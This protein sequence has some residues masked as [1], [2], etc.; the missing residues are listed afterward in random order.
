MVPRDMPFI[1]RR[2]ELDLLTSALADA[3]AGR[4]SAV[5]LSGEPGIGKTRLAQEY[6][7]YAAS[8]GALVLW[9]RCL[10]LEGT[11][12]FWP[13][14]EVIRAALRACDPDT[15][16]RALGADAATIARLAPEL[17]PA[18]EPARILP[19]EEEPDFDDPRSR[20]RLFDATATFLV[21]LAA[22]RT[23][24]LVLDDLHWA[25]RPSLVLLQYL[26]RL[27]RDAHLLVAGLYRD[28]V[29]AR[30]HPLAGTMAALTR[31]GIAQKV[32]LSGWSAEEVTR[33]AA[34]VA[35]GA[36]TTD[37][38]R[39]IH[40]QTDGNPF[41]VI[42]SLRLLAT[43]DPKTLRDHAPTGAIP[44]G[45]RAVVD[46]RL[47]QLSSPCQEALALA[48]VAGST[49]PLAV[50][51]RAGGGGRLPLLAALEEAE[52]ARLILQAPESP[53][54]FRFA[55][56]LFR[57]ALYES[58]PAIRRMLLHRAVGEA[59]ESLAVGAD[60]PLA[61]LA[62]HFGRAAPSGV[63]E[64][65]VRYAV[66][67]AEQAARALA[68][69]DAAAL[70]RAAL[71]I[72]ATRRPVDTLERC[73]LLLALGQA[74]WSLG[75]AHTARDTFLAAAALA[76]SAA[77]PDLLTRAALGYS[78]HYEPGEVEPVRIGL[79]RE[80][81]ALLD[82][83]AGSLRAQVMAELAQ[84]LYWANAREERE[85]LSREAVALARRLDD[86]PTLGRV[87]RLRTL[88][89]WNPDTTEERLA[90]GDEL[91]R[92]G[93]ATGNR[94]LARGGAEIRYAAL[95][96]LGDIA[97]IDAMLDVWPAEAPEQRHP[98]RRWEAAM[99][100][101][102]RVLLAGRLD[103]AERLAGEAVQAGA[104]LQDQG[105]VYLYY[106][107]QIFA[108][109]REQDRLAE[110]EPAIR[111][112]AERYPLIPAY[113][114]GLAWIA[115]E[116]D[117]PDEARSLLDTLAAD[118]FAAIPFDMG[119]PVA[120]MALAQACAALG[121]AHRAASLYRLLLP[122]ANRCIVA[123]QGAV[124]YGS[125]SLPL[126]LLAATICR[127]GAHG[128]STAPSR[129]TAARHF[130]DALAVN[131]RMGA[132][133]AL[134]WTQYQY[135][136]FLLDWNAHRGTMN[137]DEC[138]MMHRERHR[139]A[140]PLIDQARSTARELGMTRLLRQIEAFTARSTPA[141]HSS[142]IP[143]RSSFPD[144]LTAREVQ[145]LR[146]LAAGKSNRA[147][148]AEC[149]L[150]IRTVERHIANIYAKIG[151]HNKAEATAYAFRHGLITT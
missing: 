131:A 141:P 13:W 51:E 118:E 46:Q 82:P 96:E 146:L 104:R 114:A 87:L 106:G 121:D 63:E 134:A 111:A 67:A 80:A 76:R 11:P 9:G 117:R 126:A 70:Y 105:A 74:Q 144:A 14:R 39:A 79:L 97:A 53:G 128:D 15:L 81:L 136:A 68:Y 69:E 125:A 23:L 102:M 44:P 150:S 107:M 94:A 2:R 135:A 112:T 58:L 7:A 119:W 62:F 20:F 71:Q 100:R 27:L 73:R 26:G 103:E 48:A 91:L 32:A 72:L 60:P 12:A 38:A 3:H 64:K 59:L 16:S 35:G 30:E 18:P 19:D 40:Q 137:N 4:G 90:T 140:Q 28:A 17:R 92:L 78:L 120:V 84:A 1:G 148:A 133:L 42:E 77:S 115:C 56:A 37:Q 52:R 8:H 57:E 10:Q 33:A 113:R 25:D 31:E 88:A 21:R 101:A 83:S 108:I 147:I 24:V 130:R 145:M 122:Y 132:R 75:D 43:R 116:R 29:E 55:H 99:T 86:P 93:A 85:A 49:F 36:L 142:F 5:L 65:A 6:G 47:A 110:V 123:G 138:G 22:G 98:A 109:R 45:A 89:A 127:G 95:L 41:F 66:A 139:A 54:R 50:L 34:L 124:C 129:E 151:A 61:E 143:R 149:V